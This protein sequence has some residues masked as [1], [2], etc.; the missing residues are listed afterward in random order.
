LVFYNL[1][2][3]KR[4][5]YLL[6][7]YPA[8]SVIVAVIFSAPIE[9]PSSVLES[10]TKVLC[11]AAG[12]SFIT[13]GIS[14]LI[15]G[16]MLFFWPQPLGWIIARFGILVTELSP[17]LHA[18]AREH[19][20]ATVLIP[21]T[22]VTLGAWMLASRRPWMERIVGGI[23]GEMVAIT[24]AVNLIVEPAIANTLSPKEFALDATERAGAR[25][26]YGFGS[27]DYAYVFYSG[28]DARF[29][30]VDDPPELITGSEEQWPL[31]P[32]SF[33]GRYRAMLRSNPTESD[34]SGRLLLLRRADV[35]E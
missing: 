30:S 1:P 22:T 23:A 12:T 18:A 29:V 35:S 16:A 32:E 10:W 25:I 3:S 11:C 24:L 28:R 6:A 17:A 27:L 8:L 14:A 9:S 2:Y 19:W 34:G 7:L 31:M 13:A 33:R 26:I 4:G 20:L 15:G 21:L 5:V